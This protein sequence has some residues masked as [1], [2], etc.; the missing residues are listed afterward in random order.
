MPR[1]RAFLKNDAERERKNYEDICGFFGYV[2]N[3]TSH[4]GRFYANCVREMLSAHGY[5]YVPTQEI[6]HLTQEERAALRVLSNAT[7]QDF[8]HRSLRLINELTDVFPLYR[9]GAAYCTPSFK[10][11]ARWAVRSNEDAWGL[12]YAV[13]AIHYLD[14]ASKGQQHV[15]TLLDIKIE[16][17]AQWE[18]DNDKQQPRHTD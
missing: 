14:S 15:R 8:W 5:V 2:S 4:S 7:G 11:F 17:L 6:T 3:V 9:Q 1:S 18:E 16:E 12:F 13:D 10:Y